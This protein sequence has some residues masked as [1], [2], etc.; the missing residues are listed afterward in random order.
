MYNGWLWEPCRQ[1][2]WFR[3]LCGNQC[4]R[5]QP[6][7]IFKISCNK[8][9]VDFCVNDCY[10]WIIISFVWISFIISRVQLFYIGHTSSQWATAG[11]VFAPPIGRPFKIWACSCFAP[12][13]PHISVHQ[14][15]VSYWWLVILMLWFGKECIEMIPR[16]GHNFCLSKI[17]GS[18]WAGVVYFYHCFFNGSLTLWIPFAIILHSHEFSNGV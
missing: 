9:C 5:F 1:Q 14:S 7:F 12:S 8:V 15:V 18:Q 13:S 6:S 10:C 17:Q 2:H 4:S 3:F 16:M 11:T